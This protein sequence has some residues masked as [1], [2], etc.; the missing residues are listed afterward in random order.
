MYISNTA[1]GDVKIRQWQTSRDE[2]AQ[3]LWAN[4]VLQATNAQGLGT[5][6]S[7]NCSIR[8]YMW[9]SR[10]EI[11]DYFV[12]Y[13]HIALFEE[14]Y[15]W[16]SVEGRAHY[17][18]S[19]YLH[20]YGTCINSTP[21]GS[22]EVRHFKHGNSIKLWDGIIFNFYTEPSHMM[23]TYRVY[24]CG[25]STDMFVS[26]RQKYTKV[27]KPCKFLLFTSLYFT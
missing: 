4:F 25:Q 2:R 15:C 10:V 20:I 8:S 27:K 16:T 17:T 18:L 1:S 14:S 7:T 21:N 9:Q 24:S 13:Y 3:A 12:T 6:L 5:R 23:V 26:V 11:K 22:S 19:R